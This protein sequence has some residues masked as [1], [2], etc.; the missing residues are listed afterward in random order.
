LKKK[1]DAQV[2]KDLKRLRELEEKESTVGLS[3]EERTEA[4]LRQLFLSSV[5]Q[6]N[7]RSISG[8]F[9]SRKGS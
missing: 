3:A 1:I 9:G 5:A 6:G 7:V 4:A 8:S 2:K